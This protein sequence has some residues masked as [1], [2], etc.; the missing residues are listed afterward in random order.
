MLPILHGEVGFQAGERWSY[1]GDNLLMQWAD[2]ELAAYLG[3]GF[4]LDFF[5]FVSEI[6]L[7]L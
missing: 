7:G 2:S 1:R 5:F 6:D 3:F 4:D